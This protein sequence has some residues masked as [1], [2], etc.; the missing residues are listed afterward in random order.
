MYV[1]DR[2]ALAECFASSLG[3]VES[4]RLLPSQVVTRRSDSTQHA[5]SMSVTPHTVCGQ[6]Q[7][8]AWRKRRACV[9][10]PERLPIGLHVIECHSRLSRV[11]VSQSLHMGGDKC[12]KMCQ[13]LHWLSLHKSPCM[14]LLSCSADSAVGC[15][16]RPSILHTHLKILHIQRQ[17]SQWKY[18]T[19]KKTHVARSHVIMKPALHRQVRKLGA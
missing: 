3:R 17:V 11:A 19:F 18:A 8:E 7:T 5:T 10:Q 12:V 9:Q 15:C 4:N 2:H 16:Q 13:K 14:S 1:R 6:T